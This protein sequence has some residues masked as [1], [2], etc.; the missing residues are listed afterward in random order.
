MI[1]LEEQEQKKTPTSNL[2]TNEKE[3]LKSLRKREDTICNTENKTLKFNKFKRRITYSLCGVI[4]FLE[5]I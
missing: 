3:T 1:C 2:S 5:K 4:R